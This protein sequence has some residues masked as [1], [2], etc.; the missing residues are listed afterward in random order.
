MADD[1]ETAQMR[2]IAK[3]L[4]PLYFIS[5]SSLSFFSSYL[6]VLGASSSQQVITTALARRYERKEP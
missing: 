2:V 1:S 5:P 3:R 4:F 6:L